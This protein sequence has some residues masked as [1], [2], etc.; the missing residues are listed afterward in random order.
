MMKLLSILLLAVATIPPSA[1]QTAEGTDKPC[2]MVKAEARRLPDLNTPRTGHAAFCVNGELTVAG[3]HTTGFVPT[4]TAEYFHDGEW[5]QVPMIYTHDG[6]FFVS[7]KSGRV[8]IG[9]GFEKEFGVGQTLS[10]EFYD[11]KTHTFEASSILSTKRV[12]ATAL[13][14]DSGRVIISGNWYADDCTEVF[15]G[16]PMHADGSSN[17]SYYNKVASQRALPY[18][19]RTAADDALIIGERDTKAHPTDTIIADRLK[20]DALHIPLFGKWRPLFLA[21]PYEMQSCFIGDEAKGYYAYL[22]PVA[23]STGQITIA[24]VEGEAVS[25]LPTA[26]PIPMLSPDGD[27]ISY[28][29]VIAD[30]KAQRAYLVGTDSRRIVYVLCIAYGQAQPTAPLTLYYTDPLPDFGNHH[31]VLTADGNLAIL[32]GKCGVEHNNYSPLASAW[33][34]LLTPT[35]ASSQGGVGLWGWL[36]LAVV[37]LIA[38]ITLLSLWRRKRKQPAPSIALSPASPTTPLMA[39]LCQL[40]EQGQLFLNSELKVADIAEKLGTNSR[41]VSEIIKAERGCSF[42]DFVN[43][44]RIDYAKQ[45]LRQQPDIKVSEVWLRSGFAS[46]QTFYR[47]FKNVTGMTPNDMRFG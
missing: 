39:D 23:D 29:P 3:G 11:P 16:L 33:L 5:H 41:K 47:I 24:K 12:G 26:S 15:D 35:E 8:L 38:I 9:G 46:E 45:L 17:F 32:G 28:R 25:L 31:P 2:P 43:G 40:M 27:S 19:L 6:G 44:Y 37:G 18:I 4:K 36:L 1:A 42:T 30:R 22:L 10:A 21:E 34:I 14:L 20:G 7:M 13:E